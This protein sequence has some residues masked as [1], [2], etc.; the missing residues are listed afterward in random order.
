MAACALKELQLNNCSKQ[1]FCSKKYSDDIQLSFSYLL[2]PSKQISK[3]PRNLF[4]EIEHTRKS[5]MPQERNHLPPN[6]ILPRIFVIKLTQEAEKGKKSVFTCKAM[7]GQVP[8]VQRYQQPEPKTPQQNIIWND[9]SQP[10]TL[11]SSTLKLKKPGR[12]KQ[13]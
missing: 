9:K 8:G 4:I 1:H 2:S 5:T 7:P 10:F 12:L 3:L 13:W 6:H 11:R